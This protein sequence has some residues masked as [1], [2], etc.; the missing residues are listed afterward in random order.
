MEMLSLANRK[1]REDE[2]KFSVYHFAKADALLGEFDRARQHWKQYP[3]IGTGP[4][5]H[6]LLSYIIRQEFLAGEFRGWDTMQNDMPIHKLNTVYSS[7]SGEDDFYHAVPAFYFD[8]GRGFGRHKTDQEI[9][10][11]YNTLSGA[12]YINEDELAFFMA[13]V[14]T[15]LMEKK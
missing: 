10:A 9:M 2:L 5:S 6:F 7:R 12:H 14:A 11:E 8:Y 13:G 4:W 1:F 15:G 3:T